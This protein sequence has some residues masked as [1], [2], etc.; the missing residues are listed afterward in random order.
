VPVCRTLQAQNIDIAILT[1]TRIPDADGAR[2]HTR[3]CLGY[4]IYATYTTTQNQGG[5]A[6]AY[7]QD[8]TNWHIE[9]QQRHGPN[10]I[11][12]ILVSADKRTPLIGAYLPPSHLNDL[13]YLTQALDRFPN[14]APILLGDLN[15]DIH[16]LAASQRNTQVDTLLGTYG[17]DD[18]LIHFRQ[19][20]PFRH[21]KTWH[22]YRSDTNTIH[23]SRCD[24]ILGTDRR[25]FQSVGIRD[26]RHFS[27]D[28]YMVVATYLAKPQRSHKKYLLGRKTFPLKLPKWG[29]LP[30][31]DALYE[32]L[33]DYWDPPPPSAK[34]TK[35]NWITQ[36][37]LQLMDAR[38]SLRRN[39]RHNRTEARRLSRA[40]NARL[41][42]DR[43]ART[44]QAGAAIQ[45][46][47]DG[48]EPNMRQ[49]YKIL[50]AWYKHHGDRPPKPSRTDLQTLTTQ[51]RDLYTKETPCPPGAPIPVHIAPYPI[52]DSI[53]DEAEI[54]RTV[55]RLKN[56]KATGPSGLPNEQL[57]AFLRAARHDPNDPDTPDP[58]LEPWDTLVELVQY[59]FS[60]G[61]IPQ[62][63][64]WSHLA[65]LPKSDGGVRGVGLLEHT[66]KICEA[67]I[68]TR[69]KREVKFHDIIHGLVKGRGT[70]TAIIEAKLQQEL[71]NIQRQPLFQ[72]FLDLKKAYDSV[73]R[74]RTL[75][76]LTQYGM[77]PKLI[78]LLRNFWS[79]QNVVIRQSG[80][81]GT[82]IQPERGQTQGGV[83]AGTLFN[84][85]LDAVIR[86]WLTLVVNDNGIVTDGFGP[87][88]GE[89]MALFYADDGLL[90]STDHQWLQQ[91]LDVLIGLFRRMGLQTNAAKTKTMTTFPHYVT[92]R[93]TDRAYNRRMT[94]AGDTHRQ[95]QRQRVTC[96]NC[97]LDLARGSLRQH[98][99][100][101][102]DIEYNPWDDELAPPTTPTA[103]YRISF[104][105][106]TRSR[107]C[108]V[109]HCTGR[110]A[111]KAAL[112]EHFQ[113]RHPA[114]TICILEEG[115]QPLPRCPRCDMHVTPL[116]I[117][118]G[119]TNTAAC[120]RGA[121]LLQRRQTEATIRRAR[122]IVF[123]ANGTDLDR[124]PNFNYL[125]RILSQGNT[126]WPT[127]YKNLKKARAKWT[128][129]SR[130]LIKTGVS[131]RTVGLFT[132][133]ITQS[134]LLY[135]SETW[136]VTPQ[137]LQ[138]LESFTHRIARRITNKMPRLHHGTWHYPPLEDAMV[139][140]GF[141]P[142]TE[143]IHRRQNH[144]ADYI[145]TRPVFDLCTDTPDLANSRRLRWWN[146]PLLT[147][148]HLNS[149][150]EMEDNNDDDDDD[151]DDL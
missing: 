59:M 126:D 116:A 51:F 15:A 70:S 45:A 75:N 141:Y 93:M 55:R 97:D 123:R 137:M 3:N 94:N 11:S 58:I 52:D 16:N 131:E 95:R 57:K 87:T 20:K 13:P 36:P 130:P 68:D 74:D 19:R 119:H 148:P 64:T 88:V 14:Q 46:A 56:Y 62:K 78:N 79:R 150:D 118:R 26:P 24:Y 110:A 2:V 76:L 35:P 91:A 12:C 67:I 30:K 42:L 22:Q 100:R 145:A 96:P 98:R 43:K 29:P 104:P 23:R 109:P 135:G 54:E 72:I 121:A 28:H 136:V 6:L 33:L 84:I 105:R 146:Q 69:V 49:S 39:P 127:T 138:P 133:A 111:T 85:L 44:E 41:K 65:I 18:M 32:Q 38:C 114:D 66:W 80:F 4:T 124:V 63:L 53:P 113:R 144:I 82:P 17:L 90:S 108:P 106:T 101:A 107:T 112:Q 102:H 9:S 132:K 129:I 31:A 86:H 149:D 61:D 10:V 147:R 21:Y 71:A 151:E 83:F 99:L 89:R 120:A 117:N 8:A 103:S 7:K 140:A 37:T 40:I 143:Y 1:E 48:P 128:L 125:G 134:V 27:T 139:E 25:L 122:E 77:G 73:D 92:T 60:T 81:H 115:G 47:L 5:I 34:K 142:I 50:Q